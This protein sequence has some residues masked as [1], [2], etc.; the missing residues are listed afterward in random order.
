MKNEPT[1]LWIDC[2]CGA[3]DHSIQFTLWKNE[4]LE[5]PEIYVSMIA[6]GNTGF[7]TRVKDALR[8][9]FKGGSLTF[10]EAILDENSVEEL[11]KLVTI[12]KLLSRMRKTKRDNLTAS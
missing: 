9:V 10:N 12:H 2:K 3:H 4:P 8:Y 5:D 6:T 1:K 7:W 11:H